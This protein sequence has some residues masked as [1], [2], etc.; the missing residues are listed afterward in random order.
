L[1]SIRMI[2]ELPV[3]KLPTWLVKDTDFGNLMVRFKWV[4]RK[5]CCVFRVPFRTVY[6]T[7]YILQSF[8]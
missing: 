3:R 4:E 5:P 6:E 2:L 8:N 1:I 7:R